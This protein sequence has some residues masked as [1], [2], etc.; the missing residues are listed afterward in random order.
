MYQ[1]LASHSGIAVFVTDFQLAQQ[2]FY[3]ARRGLADPT[4]SVLQFRRSPFKPE[5]ELWITKAGAE[6]QSEGPTVPSLTATL[7]TLPDA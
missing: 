3:A 2:R 4:L 6:A 7:G 1:A 5:E